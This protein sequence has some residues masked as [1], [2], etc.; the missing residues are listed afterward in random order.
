MGEI[1]AGKPALRL[2]VTV[3]LPLDLVSIMSLLYR[4]VPGSGLAPWLVEARRG[5]SPAVR[6]DLDLLHGF[7]GRLLYYMEEPVMRFAPLLPERREADFGELMAFL[8]RRPPTE[9][10]AMVA[11]ALQRVHRDLETGLVP[12]NSADEDDWRR[13]LEPALTTAD[14]ETTL[15]LIADPV[16]LKARTLGLMRGIWTERYANDYE[17]RVAT[18]RAAASAAEPAAGREFGVAYAELTGNRVPESLTDGLADVACVV[19]CPSYHLGHF[20][21]YILY[22]PDGIVFFGAPELLARVGAGKGATSPVS[23]NGAER[24]TL[25]DEGALEAFRALA[26]ANRLRILDLLGDGELY[27]QEI[28]GR[29]GTAQSAVSRHLAILERAGLVTVRPRRGMKYYAVDP[30][31]MATLADL[32]RTHGPH[33]R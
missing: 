16:E 7:S 29:L 8:D 31:R 32:L 1:V 30:E 3:S 6:R 2:D 26:D 14:L 28:V 21:S 10:R 12:W 23:P 27:A 33:E 4:A 25:H 24:P 18:L 22:P 11:H 19:F 20:D 15:T 17:R 13:F 9:Y 5:L